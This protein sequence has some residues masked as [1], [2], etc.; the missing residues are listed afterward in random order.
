[1]ECVLNGAKMGGSKLIANLARYAK[2]NVGI[3]RKKFEDAEGNG[4][5]HT[6]PFQEYKIHN[7]SFI[8]QGRGKLFSDIFTKDINTSE[9][10]SC[11]VLDTGVNIEISDETSAFKELIGRALVGRCRT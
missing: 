5:A 1:M 6:K 9:I 11:L 7:N 8:K 10:K 3:I 4:K 2:E